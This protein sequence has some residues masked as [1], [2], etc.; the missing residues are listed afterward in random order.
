MPISVGKHIPAPGATFV[1]SAVEQEEMA[2]EEYD[3]VL[4]ELRH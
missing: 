4:D 1:M 2:K 3:H